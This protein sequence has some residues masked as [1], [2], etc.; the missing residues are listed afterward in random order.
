MSSSCLV[1]VDGWNHFLAVSRCFGRDFANRFPLDRVATHVSAET[2]AALVVDAVV[3]MALPDRNEPGEL[4]AFHA[5]RRRLRRLN[6]YGVRHERARFSYHQPT[7]SQCATELDRNVTCADCGHTNLLS[8][9][10]KEKGADIAL[11][12]LATEGAWRQ[13]YSSLVVLSQD[14]D[15]APMVR[16]LKDIHKAQDRPYKLYSAFPTCARS[17]HEHRSIPGTR[18]LPLTSEVYQKLAEQP[19]TQV[20]EHPA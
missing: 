11:A 10:R 19:N 15:Y 2:G 1:L 17:D 16:Q 7:C 12:L 9:R 14:S 18:E 5:W 13:Q 4:P 6:N 3:V 20:V 8:G